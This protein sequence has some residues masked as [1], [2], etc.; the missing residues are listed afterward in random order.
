MKNKDKSDQH[1]VYSDSEKK[2]QVQPVSNRDKERK[3]D[4]NS[5]AT[6][7]IRQSSDCEEKTDSQ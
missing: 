1:L 4:I 6:R 3:T 7:L 2:N 5:D